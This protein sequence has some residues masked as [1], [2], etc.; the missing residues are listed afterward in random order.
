MS[1]LKGDTDRRNPPLLTHPLQ[2]RARGRKRSLARTPLAS[3]NHWLC[4][5][6]SCRWNHI[7][8]STVGTTPVSLSLL[9]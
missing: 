8:R 3:S 7:T 2:M 1:T 4:V 5:E 6:H 9:L